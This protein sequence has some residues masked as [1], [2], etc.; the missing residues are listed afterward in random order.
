MQLSLLIYC[1]PVN[2]PRLVPLQA[3]RATTINVRPTTNA[4]NISARRGDVP[5]GQS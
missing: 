4:A 5:Q 2:S 3:R 1:P